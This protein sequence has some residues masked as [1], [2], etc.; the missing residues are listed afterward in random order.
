MSPARVTAPATG[1]IRTLGPG[2][3]ELIWFNGALVNLKTPAEWSDGALVMAEIAMPQGRA[4]GLHTDPSHETFYVLEGELLFHLDGEEHRA[5]VGEVVSIPRGVPHAF[6]AMSEVARFLYVNTPGTH[7]RLFRG[8][9]VP[10]TDTDFASAP[11]PDH[12][13]TLAAANE[14][15]TEFLGPPPFSDELVRLTSG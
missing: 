13:R 9:G 10:A 11:P 2:A 6:I 12:E 1:S 15:G 7:D 8:G 3:G 4:T 14:V 5:P